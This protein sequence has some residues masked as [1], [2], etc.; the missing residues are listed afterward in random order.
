MK[1][2]D[3]ILIA[4]NYAARN[5]LVSPWEECIQKIMEKLGKAMLVSRLGLHRHFDNDDPYIG[6]VCEYVSPGVE[7]LIDN[8]F[9]QQFH[10]KRLGFSGWFDRLI[11]EQ[12]IIGNIADY[13]ESKRNLF[14]RIGV[15]SHIVIPIFVGQSPWG[16]LTL[17]DCE[18]VRNWSTAEIDGLRAF[19]VILSAAMER[20]N[21]RDALR[22]TESL[23]EFTSDMSEGIIIMD[24]D[25]RV[26]YANQALIRFSEI[27]STD[28]LI[29]I[30]VKPFLHPETLN[31]S[32]SALSRVKEG[33]SSGSFHDHMIVSRNGQIRYLEGA[34]RKV[35]FKGKDACLVSLRDVTEKRIAQ[36][37][38][39]EKSAELVRA[40]AAM[41]AEI[42]ERKKAEE[43]LRE[44]E[45]LFRNLVENMLDC[46]LIIDLNGDILFANDAAFRLV[47]AS[48]AD[49][50]GRKKNIMD[51]LSSDSREKTFEALKLGKGGKRSFLV[52]YKLI[53]S[54]GEEIYVEGVGKPIDFKGRRAAIVNVRD[55]TDRKLAEAAIRESERKLADIIQFYPDATMVIDQNGKV[56]LWNNAIMEMTGIPAE[57]MVGRDKYEYSLPFY[58]ERRPI[59]VD[60][61]MKPD[62]EVEREYTSITRNGTV[63]YGESYVPRL[64]N[65]SHYLV[66]TAARLHD[67][68][69]NI[70]GAIESIRDVTHQKRL[71]EALAKSEEKYRELV[72]KARSIIMRIDI[73]GNIIF[74]NEYAEKFFGFSQQ[75]ILGKNLIG[76]IIPDGGTERKY[77]RDLLES[78]IKCPEKYAYYENENVCRDGAR[79]WISWTNAPVYDH[80]GEV[81]EVLCIGNDVSERKKAEEELRRH[82]EHLEE[83]VNERTAELK[84]ANERLAAAY[85]DLKASEER[86]I[87]QEKMASI[88][89]LASGIAHEIKNPLAIILQGAEFVKSSVKDDFLMDALDRIKNSSLR[90]DEIIKGLLSYSRQTD[91]N[92][93]KTDMKTVIEDSILLINHQLT[94]KS[95]IVRRDYSAVPQLMIDGNQ[96][97]QVFINILMNSIEAVTNHGQIHID[98]ESI[99]NK[100]NNEMIKIQFTDNG[101]GIAKEDVQKIFDPFFTTKR[102]TGG[103]GLGLS[104]TKGIIEKHKGDIRIESRVGVGTKITV[105]LP[106]TNP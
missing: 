101:A 80:N 81:I 51:F 3:A 21:A 5:L 71:E 99:T 35:R 30:N 28:E 25:G 78:M 14:A 11:T 39:E 38:L 86:L 36:K 50:E 32:M 22:E 106:A 4:I 1:K 61:V 58:G 91:L 57:K 69:G 44:S 68:E 76:T 24:W 9:F 43:A 65:E 105:F 7:P 34:G 31:L 79:A 2:D 70:I 95:I 13:P 67:H 75:E 77:L 92:L 16:L 48:R 41:R 54:G 96:M 6:L 19:A 8:P 37:G 15:K 56:I 18:V 104:I 60:L 17:D 98:V 72:E 42:A 40:N 74:Y 45:T 87:Q 62:G 89:L 82:R 100:D 23:F 55:I 97:K 47:N 27:K 85:A 103:T 46:L 84:Y 83:M 64:R 93:E 33:K 63:L 66:A 90:A 73:K 29:D 94:R 10:Y 26:L 59:L 102:N 12:P 53:T 88:G 20:E 49:L 52:D